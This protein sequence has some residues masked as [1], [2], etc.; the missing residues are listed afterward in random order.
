[1]AP[2]LLGFVAGSAL[3]LGQRALFPLPVYAVLLLFALGV[4]AWSLSKLAAPGWRLP[5]MALAV[6]TASYGLTGLRAALFQAQ[7]LAPAL[8]GRDLVVTGVVSAM[9]QVNEA[10]TRFRLQ[11]EAEIGRAHV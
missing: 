6:V 8:E 3:Q 7:A 10:G 2:G 4:L 1:M 11:V 9:P 5:L